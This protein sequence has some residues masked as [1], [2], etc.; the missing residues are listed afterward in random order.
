MAF[1]S[2]ILGLAQIPINKKFHL[3][4]GTGEVDI[5]PK[6]TAWDDTPSKTSW[7]SMGI[8]AQGGLTFEATREMFMKKTGVPAVVQKIWIIGMDAKLSFNAEE[9]DANQYATALGG[10]NPYTK[11]S[12][13][14]DVLIAGSK[15]NLLN[16]TADPVVTGFKLNHRLQI[17]MTGKGTATE[18]GY[19]ITLDSVAKTIGIYPDLSAAPAAAGNVT[20]IDN[21]EIPVGSVILKDNA[22]RL[23]ATSVEGITIVLYL[24]EVISVATFNLAIGEGKE[25]Y[26]LPYQFMALGQRKDMTLY[27]GSTSE[28]VIG[29]V[30][31]VYAA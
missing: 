15:V 2:A 21:K 4:L 16:M 9:L 22:V 12:I 1:T 13:I 23:V 3:R 26:R 17:E 11:L 10:L 28:V 14:T 18:D 25:N 7:V 31:E 6:N 19:V 30:Y 24:P 8:V 29:S 20:K 27:G 5:A